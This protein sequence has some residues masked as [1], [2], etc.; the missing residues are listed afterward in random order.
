[1][2]YRTYWSVLSFPTPEDLPDPGIEPT[3][4]SC[5]AG[6]FFTIRATREAQKIY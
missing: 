4:P 2:P 3:S 1:M 5:I 6:R